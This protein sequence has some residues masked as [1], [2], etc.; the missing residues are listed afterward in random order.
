MTTPNVKLSRQD[1]AKQLSMYIFGFLASVGLTLFAYFSV[2]NKT[3]SG[4][5][6]ALIIVSLAVVQLVVQLIFFLHIGDDSRPRWKAIT[7]LFALVILLI[8]VVGSVWIMHNLNY[9]MMPSDV[10]MKE[11]MDDQQG[12]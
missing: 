5:T 11:Y 12:I 6:L 7:F 9:N 10:E 4:W 8:I 3:F 2:V 1:Y